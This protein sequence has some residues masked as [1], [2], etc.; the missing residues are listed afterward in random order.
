MK[1]TIIH[2]NFTN[3]TAYNVRPLVPLL[4]FDAS[5]SSY[6]LEK[7][8]ILLHFVLTP[9][10]ACTTQIV[11]ANIPHKHQKVLRQHSFKASISGKEN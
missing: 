3:I 10:A 7:L 4:N 2:A 1:V 6:N 9:K 5:F 8:Y 11:K